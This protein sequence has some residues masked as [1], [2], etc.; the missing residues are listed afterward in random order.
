VDHASL[1]HVVKPDSLLHYHSANRRDVDAAGRPLAIAPE[2][3]PQ[4]RRPHLHRLE[5]DFQNLSH[6]RKFDAYRRA[7]IWICRRAIDQNVN[8]TELSFAMGDYVLESRG[9]RNVCSYPASPVSTHP[10]V[11]FLSGRTKFF[12]FARYQEDSRP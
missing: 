4:L 1:G 8:K 3:R 5:I 7:E 12:R 10:L 2:I 9:I 6:G 11:D